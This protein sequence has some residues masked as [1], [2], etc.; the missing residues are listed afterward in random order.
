[1]LLD[2]LFG[3]ATA[4]KVLAFVAMN[5]ETYARELAERFGI[6]LSMVQNQLLRLEG[7]GVLVSIARGRTRLFS[8]NPRYPLAEDLEAMLRRAVE[9]MPER[10]RERYLARRRPRAR[11]KRL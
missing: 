4:G 1:V 2:G 3:N 6:S 7:A 8:F 10:E 5:R 9:L 11:G